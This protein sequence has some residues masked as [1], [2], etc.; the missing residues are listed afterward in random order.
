MIL[1][2]ILVGGF[3][4]SFGLSFGFA[5]EYRDIIRNLGSGSIGN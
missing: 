1:I 5:S 3:I 2:Y 4:S